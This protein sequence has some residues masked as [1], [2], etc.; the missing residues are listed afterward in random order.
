M[1]IDSTTT[2][3]MAASQ[4]EW[5]NAESHPVPE[6]SSRIAASPGPHLHRVNSLP[7]P[8]SRVSARPRPPSILVAR[9]LT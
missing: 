2:A 6:G 7:N 9:L 1:A 3:A 8:P 4:M 5:V